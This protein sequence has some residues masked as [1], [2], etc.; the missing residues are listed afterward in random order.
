MNRQIEAK[1]GVPTYDFLRTNQHLGKNILFLTVAGSTAYGTNIAS[2]DL[3]LRGFCVELKAD[4]MGLSHFEQF[5]DRSTDTVIYGLKK[6]VQLCLNSNPNTL[7]MLGTEDEHVVLINEEGLLLRK[8]ADLFLSKKVIQSFGNYAAAQ[9]RRLKNALARDSCPATEK[10]EHI[11]ESIQ[12]SMAFLKKSYG[13]FDDSQISLYIDYSDKE[14]VATEIFMDVDLKHYSLR[15]FKNIY[16]SMSNIVK[17]YDKLKHWNRKKDELHL[18]KHAM[19]LIR[20]LI[21]GTDVLEGKGLSIYR[22]DDR[23]LLLDIRNGAYSYEAIFEMVDEQEK[24]FHAAAKTTQLPDEPQYA[25]VEALM[26]SIYEKYLCSN[27][28]LFV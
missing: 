3:D 24:R 23:T 18:N 6:F 20:L 4:I 9:L 7:E 2:S 19:H 13:D 21:T 28:K 14:D 15:D 25:A 26:V 22:K 5:E 12:S 11:L 17:D 27:D 10:E 1:L 8:H 16:A